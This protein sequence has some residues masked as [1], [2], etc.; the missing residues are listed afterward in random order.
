MAVAAALSCTNI[1]SDPLVVFS[2]DVDTIPSP[3]VVAADTL[4]DTNGVV[5]PLKAQGFNIHNKPLPNAR[6]EFLSLTPSQLTIDSSNFAYG[7]PAGDSLAR[8]IASTAGFQSLPFALP[9]VLRPDGIQHADTDS[10][11]SV[12]L[13]LTS[14]DSNISVPLTLILKHIPDTAFGD[15]VTRSYLVYYQI[16]YPPAA[17]VGT[18]TPSDTSLPAYLS[19]G[20]NGIPARTD[21]TDANGMAARYVQFNIF[22]IPPGTVDTIIVNATA[23]YPYKKN[24]VTGSPVTW[25]IY[26]TAPGT[27]SYVARPPSGAWKG[28]VIPTPRVQTR[29]ANR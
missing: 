21:T 16:V 14:L 12:S 2:M 11:T 24:T 20:L 5:T 13:S 28:I 22:H 15:S 29:R 4:R 17:A 6:I 10:I 18:G 25:T 7:T 19:T 9:V 27:S 3:S 26:V 8:V 23:Q 1:A